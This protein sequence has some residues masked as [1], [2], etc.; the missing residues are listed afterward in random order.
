MEKEQLT[1]LEAAKTALQATP[2]ASLRVPCY[3][4]ENVWRLAYRK[5]CQQ[6]DGETYHVA[7]VSNPKGCVPMFQQK[8]AEDPYQPVMWDYHVILLMTTT[9]SEDSRT[10]TTYVLDIDS[11]LPYPCPLE[12]YAE[13]VFLNHTDWK[14]EFLPYFRVF[15]ASTYLR[16]FSSDRSHMFNSKTKTWN[17]PPPPYKRILLTKNNQEPNSERPQNT[18]KQYMVISDQNVVDSQKQNNEDNASGQ[19]YSLSQLLQ[20]FNGSII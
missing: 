19:I 4:E 18:L 7:F 17:A 11:H 2:D 5:V 16:H 20:R 9:S 10:S 13:R 15:G 14:E 3:C 6:K 12:E 1:S 8:A